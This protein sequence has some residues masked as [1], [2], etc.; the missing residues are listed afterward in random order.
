MIQKDFV[1]IFFEKFGLNF[2]FFPLEKR[3]RKKYLLHKKVDYTHL[4]K[5]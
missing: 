1:S 3:K 4:C 5:A 2:I